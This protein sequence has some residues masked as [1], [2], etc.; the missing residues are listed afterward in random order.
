MSN[1]IDAIV[2]DFYKEIRENISNILLICLFFLR[3]GKTIAY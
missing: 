2:V 1:F 3:I